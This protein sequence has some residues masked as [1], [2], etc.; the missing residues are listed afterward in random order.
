MQVGDYEGR[1]RLREAISRTSH[2]RLPTILRRRRKSRMRIGD[3]DLQINVKPEDVV[4]VPVDK[5]FQ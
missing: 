1:R 2:H 4:I 3:R 5:V